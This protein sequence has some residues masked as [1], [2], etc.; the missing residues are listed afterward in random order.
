MKLKTLFTTLTIIITFFNG[1]CQ[2]DNFEITGKITNDYSGYIYLNYGNKTDS[3]LV[4][5]K[6]FSFIGKVSYPIE[7]FLHTKNGVTSESVLYLENSK[8][9]VNVSI[10][11][12]TVAINSIKGNKTALILSDLQSYFQQIESDSDFN[13][14]LYEK[15][16]T[17]ITQNPKSQFSGTILSEIAADPIF[18]YQQVYNLFNKLDISTQRSEEIKSIKA[19]LLKLKNIKVGTILKDFQLTDSK[20][21]Y[22][23]TKD[24]KKAIL[25]IEFWATYCAPC[26]EDNPKL[27][28]IYT[29]YKEK[30]F[31]I[32]GVSFDLKKESWIKAIKDDNL[33]WTNTFAEKGSQSEAIKSLGIQQLPSNF[34]VDTNGKILSIDIK[35]ADLRQYLERYLN[36]K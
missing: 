36:S 19:S 2:N 3:T 7:S 25:L 24:L 10:N 32:Y 22:I 27:V 28:E 8:M 9:S 6:S 18:S 34:L 15:L 20:G 14:K 17:I 1:L 33:Y 30:G 16:D 21:K 13:V 26:R 4:M 12:K 5:S 31:E 35:P 11:K 29:D 23:N